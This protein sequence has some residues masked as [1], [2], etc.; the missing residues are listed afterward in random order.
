MNFLSISSI[1]AAFISIVFYVI[2]ST[3][4]KP[5]EDL[6]SESQ[7]IEATQNH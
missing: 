3:Y 1:V 5:I 7:P 2:G 6:P 4:V